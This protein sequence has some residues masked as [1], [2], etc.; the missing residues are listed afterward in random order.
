MRAKMKV[1]ILLAIAATNAAA[2]NPAGRAGVDSN[3][4]NR[5]ALEQQVRQ[6]MAEVTRDRLGASDDQMVK[7]QATNQ[8]YDD[9]RRQLVQQEVQTRLALRQAMNRSDRGDAAS[10]AEVAPLLDRV[11]TLQRQRLDIQ[12]AEQKELSVYLT[13]VQRAKYFALE[14]QVRQR[15]NQM[16]QSQQQQNGGRLSRGAQIRPMA[17]RGKGIQPPPK[18]E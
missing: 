17:G 3:A 7:L 9:Q 8:K 4:A 2:Q 18:P 11:N 13:P 16:R 1:F 5:A 10:Q 6:R 14:Q 15:V 12:D